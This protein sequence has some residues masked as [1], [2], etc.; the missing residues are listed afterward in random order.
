MAGYRKRNTEGP[1]SEDK[2][3]DLFAEMMI[4]KIESIHKDWHKPWFT[5]GAL[6]WPR[7]LSGR[8]YNGMNA[9]MLCE[10]EGYK[11]PRFCTFD[12][13]Q[14]L[15]KPGK[16]GQELPRVSVLR[17]EKSFPVMLTT[18]TCIHKET[19][20]KIKY[21]DYKK[22]SDEEKAQ[23]NVYPKM[24]VFRVFNVAQ[25]NLQEARPELWEQLEREREKGRKRRTFQFWA[26]R[27]DD[28]GQPLDLSHQTDAPKRS[29]LLNHKERDC[30]TRKG[31]VQRRGIFLR[32]A[33]P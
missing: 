1:S 12:C 18:F 2:A 3:L 16:D 8:E 25:T 24:Q 23:Y 15:N 14:R 17:G 30:R 5:E 27:C 33:V 21:D 11:I 26:C 9:L 31:A 28:K 7:N 32:N 6:Q 22:L 10:N 19:K 20:E 4:E 13:V 29:I